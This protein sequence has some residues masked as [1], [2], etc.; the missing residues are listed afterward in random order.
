MALSL[1]RKVSEPYDPEPAP[2]G[3]VIA[4]RCRRERRLEELRAEA[5]AIGAL[6]ESVGR[7]LQAEPE[8]VVFCGQRYSVEHL[9]RVSVLEPEDA[10][11]IG[12]DRLR[13]LIEEIRDTQERLRALG[14]DAPPAGN[15][16]D[17]VG[18]SA[19]R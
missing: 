19:G 2:P 8:R 17:V 3:S 12:I 4:E 16:V 14:D 10:A 1:V 18:R 5:A 9:H 11:R 6:M 15:G 7:Q 13:A